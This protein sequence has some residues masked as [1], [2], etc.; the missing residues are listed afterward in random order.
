MGSIGDAGRRALDR[1]WASQ[2]GFRSR[3]IGSVRA[4]V[5]RKFLSCGFVPVAEDLDATHG[6][7]AIVH[8]SNR[9]CGAGA[10]QAEADTGNVHWNKILRIGSGHCI[11]FI[12]RSAKVSVL[13][14]SKNVIIVGLIGRQT[15]VLIKELIRI[16]DQRRTAGA[17]TARGRAINIVVIDKIVVRAL[18]PTEIEFLKVKG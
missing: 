13:I 1:V 7:P 11:G 8:N 6:S 16:A 3:A 2:R 12:R 4:S 18:T 15:G 5:T 9:T 10:P 14:D 17:K